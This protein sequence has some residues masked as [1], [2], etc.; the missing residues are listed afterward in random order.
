MENAT[1]QTS[2]LSVYEERISGHLELLSSMGQD[3]ATSLDI[4]LPHLA[5]S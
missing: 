1:A 2:V 5:I 4:G 3:F